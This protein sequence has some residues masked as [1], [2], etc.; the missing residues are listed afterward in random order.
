MEEFHA[1]LQDELTVYLVFG[2]YHFDKKVPRNLR[3]S[4]ETKAEALRRRTKILNYLSKNKFIVEDFVNHFDKQLV[5]AVRKDPNQIKKIK[6]IIVMEEELK[7]H[8]SYTAA[9]EPLRK[10]FL[11]LNS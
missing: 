5:Q 2:H 7:K 4:G 6:E 11:N 8:P 9:S 3:K 1:F 10:L